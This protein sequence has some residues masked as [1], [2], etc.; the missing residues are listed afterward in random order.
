VQAR[1][2]GAGGGAERAVEAVLGSVKAP[3]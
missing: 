2:E 1:A 3:I